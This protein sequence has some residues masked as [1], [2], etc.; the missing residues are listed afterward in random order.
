MQ[1]INSPERYGAVSLLLHWGVALTVF[2][3][4]AVGLW[5]VG[6]NYY[7]PWRQ[8]VPDLHKSIGITLFVIMLLRVLW[9]FISPPPPP[10]P[11]QGWFIRTAAKLGHLALYILL[12]AVMISG[13][14]ISTAEGDGIVVFGMIK[15]PALISG[16]SGKAEL[17]GTIH[18][19][20][21]VTLVIMAVLHALA[22]LKHHFIDR[23]AT[24]VRML[25][26]KNLNHP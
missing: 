14:F 13:Y 15:V 9:R 16:I 24:L 26:I 5:M 11:N 25:G 12:F 2:A 3:M 18:L 1:L 19:Y 21:A 8:V 10:T 23:D 6:L 22:A 7:H 4:F 20:L 17:A